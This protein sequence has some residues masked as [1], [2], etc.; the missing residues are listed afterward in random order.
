MLPSLWPMGIL[1]RQHASK[2]DVPSA[3]SASN[4]PVA[5][6]RTKPN[7]NQQLHCHPRRLNL[8]LPWAWDECV[9]LSGAFFGVLTFL[10]KQLQLHTRT[11]MAV[12][13]WAMPQ[14]QPLALLTLTLSILPYAI[15]SN[16]I[17]FSWKGSTS[18]SILRT[19]LPKSYPT[20]FFI[21][22]PTIS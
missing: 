20:S 16:G 5:R 1:T 11:M 6:S 15:G 3:V 9:S 13:Q 18:L 22:M 4:L 2:L 10:R 14:N 17:L 7:S 12:P 8:W 19:T 21:N